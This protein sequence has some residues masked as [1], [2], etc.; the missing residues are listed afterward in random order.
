V[1]AGRLEL[2][3]ARR[4]ACLDGVTA[5]LSEREFAL[6][7][8]LVERAD[9]AVSRRRLLADA[10]GVDGEPGTN[11]VDV[12]VGRLRKKLGPGAPIETVRNVGYRI[13]LD[14]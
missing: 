7:R 3:L 1:R 11:M 8:C 14:E 12:C 13:A 2:D 9:H 5:D 10:W 6:L 4:Q